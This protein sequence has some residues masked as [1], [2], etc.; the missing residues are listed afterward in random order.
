MSKTK[1]EPSSFSCLPSFHVFPAITFLPMSYE[2]PF[3]DWLA[4]ILFAILSQIENCTSCV[5]FFQSQ[6]ERVS[7]EKGAESY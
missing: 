7:H 1:N 5:I 2:L 6:N 3:Y 4:R